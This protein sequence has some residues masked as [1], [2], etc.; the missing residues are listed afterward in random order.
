MSAPY[1][2]KDV[3]DFLRYEPVQFTH[4]IFLLKNSIFM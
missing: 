2:P 1:L 4:F 3:G